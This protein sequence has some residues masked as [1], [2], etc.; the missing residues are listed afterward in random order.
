MSSSAAST[1]A[2]MPKDQDCQ[3]SLYEMDPDGDLLLIVG[4][5]TIMSPNV[6]S[7]EAAATFRV[8]SSALRRQSPV[9][10]AMLF[11]PWKESKP[12][13]GS[14][15]IVKLPNDK[16]SAMKVL[17]AIVHGRFEDIPGPMSI[18][19]LDDLVILLDKYDMFKIIRP[20]AS[21]CKLVISTKEQS[22]PAARAARIHIAWEFGLESIYLK[23]LKDAV[24]DIALVEGDNDSIE[25]VLGGDPSKTLFLQHRPTL[26]TWI[27]WIN[28]W[29]IDF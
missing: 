26:V 3:P 23:T 14:E 11:G 10:K 1:E 18:F 13:D 25:P 17:L 5:P 9:W 15:W 24:M 2:T 21:K 29:D 12:T 22:D 27:F 6:G 7:E 8:C 4:N 20:W 16:L 19:Q 28:F